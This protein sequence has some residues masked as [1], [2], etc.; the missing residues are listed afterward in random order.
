MRLVTNRATFVHGPMWPNKRPAF[1][2]MALETSFRLV[3]SDLLF[4][5]TLSVRVV[6]IKAEHFPALDWV[7]ELKRKLKTLLFVAGE[8]E[9]IFVLDK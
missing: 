8:T 7:V 3:P 1:F 9:F 4:R 2:T 5:L 6:A